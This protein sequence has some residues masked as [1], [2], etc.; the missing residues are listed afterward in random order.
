MKAKRKVGFARAVELR[1]E[2]KLL[3][4]YREPTAVE[5]EAEY[6][7]VKDAYIGQQIRVFCRQTPVIT[8]DNCNTFMAEAEHGARRY[9][10]ALAARRLHLSWSRLRRLIYLRDRGRCWV[11]GRRVSAD[12]A[13]L[14]HI[15]DRFRGGSDTPENLVVMCYPCNHLFKPGHNSKEEALHWREMMRPLLT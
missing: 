8:D 14:G 6:Q 7:R 13:D 3:D 1:R 10:Y 15:V 12:E 11:C 9:A 2:L 4:R 5:V